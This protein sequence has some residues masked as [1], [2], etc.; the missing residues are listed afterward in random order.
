[1]AQMPQTSDSVVIGTSTESPVG[2]S[3]VQPS[4]KQM[5]TDSNHRLKLVVALLAT[6]A[7]CG[8]AQAPGDNPQAQQMQP[9]SMP[10]GGMPPGGMPPAQLPRPGSLNY[11]QGQVSSA[12][13]PLTLQAVGHF[14]LQPGQ[15][16]DTA[17]D[18]YVEVLLTPG[19]FLRVGPNSEFSVT[20][21]GLADTRINLTRG[22][23]LVEVDQ[24]IAGTHLE[25]T[26]AA[27]SVDM[28]K[29]GLYSFTTA[30]PG[31]SVFD[32]KADVVGQTVRRDVGK[33][34]QLALED[35]PK[36]K[37]SSFAE[38]QAKLDPLY[39]WSSARSHAESDQNKLVSQNSAGY[40]PV[41]DGWFWDPYTSFYG[42]WGPGAF[43]SPFGFSF[44]GG[45]YPGFYHGYY[46]GFRPGFYNNRGRAFV[47]GVHGNG[48]AG[49]FHGG[50]F[51]GGGFHGGGRGGGGGRR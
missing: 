43:Y 38:S 6:A 1:M 3:R 30:P 2:F 26:L 18:G 21:V 44:F 27:T 12:G 14:A 35:N 17:N 16:V 22:S 42:F 36:F 23:A 32:G 45:Y 47:G 8:F 4:G 25:V 9:G 39:V 31:V 41:G 50:G 24:L 37:K 33:H 46:G 51:H 29:K 48:I 49:G 11:V 28:L 19:A 34:D 20:A 15:A 5:K 40:Y 7:T 10:A 13:Q